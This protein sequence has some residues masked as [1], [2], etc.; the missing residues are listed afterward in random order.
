[1]AGIVL[2]GGLSSRMGRDKALLPWQGQ[3]LLAHMHDLLKRAGAGI[4]R[5]SGSYPEFDGIADVVAR[6][7]PLGGVFSVVSTLPDGPAWVVPVDMPQLDVALL[8]RLR[9][10]PH[11]ACVIFA[12]QPLPMRLNIDDACRTL[13]HS[14]IQALDGPRSLQALQ[15]RLGVLELPVSAAAAVSLVNCNTPEQWEELA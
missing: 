4:V 6:C 8:H 10:A 2:A 11:A 12:G 9:D 1:M 5:V 7:G 15:R 3:T 14:M 13:L